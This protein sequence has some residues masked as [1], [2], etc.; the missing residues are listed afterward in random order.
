[1]VNVVIEKVFE[2]MN[3]F[4]KTKE[5]K[6]QLKKTLIDFFKYEDY[7][8]TAIDAMPKA[9]LTNELWQEVA[10]AVGE[11]LLVVDN[12]VYTKTKFAEVCK[13]FTPTNNSI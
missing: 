5:C 4:F 1:M 6:E 7:G 13:S 11:E 10:D 3:E 12:L 9:L 8:V 2:Q